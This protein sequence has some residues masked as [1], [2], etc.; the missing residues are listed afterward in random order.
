MRS[1]FVDCKIGVDKLNVV[2]IGVDF[3]GLKVLL[4]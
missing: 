2:E 4:E 1:F 3:C